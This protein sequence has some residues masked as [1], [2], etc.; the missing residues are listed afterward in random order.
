MRELD[1]IVGSWANLEVPRLSHEECLR[2][3]R[4]VLCTESPSI[5]QFVLGHISPPLDKKEYFEKLRVY[6]HDGKPKD[7]VA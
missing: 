1:M 3:H 6:A 4:Q 7:F 2:Y 5:L